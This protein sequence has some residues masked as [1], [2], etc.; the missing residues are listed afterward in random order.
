M[1]LLSGSWPVERAGSLGSVFSSL[2]PHTLLSPRWG[3]LMETREKGEYFFLMV[4]IP[5]TSFGMQPLRGV[6]T[7]QACINQEAQVGGRRSLGSKP[8][9]AQHWLCSTNSHMFLGQLQ[10]FL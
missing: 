3:L 5:F 7:S 8:F 4:G 10:S 2:G 6:Q 9:L 1:V